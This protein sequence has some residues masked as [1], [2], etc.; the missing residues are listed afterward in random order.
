MKIQC[1][2]D[3]HGRTW[4]KYIKECDILLHCGDISP[5]YMEHDYYTQKQ[6]FSDQFMGE[7]IS[8]EDRVGHIVFIAGNH[9]TYLYEDYVKSKGDV[10]IFNENLPNF[11]HYLADSEVDIDGIR[12]Y[13][14]PWVNL[15]PWAKSGPPVWN[16]GAFDSELKEK[17]EKIPEG[18]DIL[19]SHGPAKSFCDKILD[20]Q[21]I[22]EKLLRNNRQQE[23]LGTKTLIQKIES[24]DSKP[25]YVFSGHIHSAK[26]D[27]EKYVGKDINN[28]CNV[29]FRC[30]SFLNEQYD[31]GYDPFIFNY[32]EK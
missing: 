15:P 21:K 11:I 26:H 16:F 17:Y 29:Q 31:K 25:K 23:N 13:G 7:L 19:I 22:A 24:L 20:K 28:P 3:T 9:D 32:K 14:T 18:L 27:F 6:W 1:I 2:S 30:V 8:L 12:I 4:A 5:V 10:S